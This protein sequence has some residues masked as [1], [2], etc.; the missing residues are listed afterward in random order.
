MYLALG[1]L[2]LVF[3]GIR[4]Q[5]SVIR[6]RPAIDIEVEKLPVE[7]GEWSG[8]NTRGLDIRSQNVLKLTRYVKRRYTNS[9]GKSV[10]LYVGYWK[11]QTGD[12]QAAKHSPE[13]CLPSNGWHINPP[14]TLTLAGS[15]GGSLTIKRL[16]GEERDNEHLFYYYFFAGERKYTEEWQA[17][18]N[19]SLQ[20]I[21]SGR[22]DG[23]IVEVS[24]PLTGKGSRDSIIAERSALVEDFLR[25]LVPALEG[26]VNGA[27]IS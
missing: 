7:L 26:L 12:Y 17:L 19:T 13:L 22:S 21:F 10:T 1:T 16:V 20:T 6:N 15:D 18:V 9:S 14:Q 8:E 24:T 23:G 11:K 4:Y 25:Q 3:F 2:V 5:V 27:L